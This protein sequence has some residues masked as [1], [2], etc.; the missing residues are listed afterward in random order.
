[1]RDFSTSVKLAHI[2]ESVPKKS[3]LFLSVEEP[4]EYSVEPALDSA[5]SE[6]KSCAVFLR[7]FVW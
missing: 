7:R 6:S 4:Y 2:T 5:R 1:M 3:T